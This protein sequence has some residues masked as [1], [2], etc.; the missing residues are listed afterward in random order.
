MWAQIIFSPKDLG[1]ESYPT[2]DRMEIKMQ[3]IQL[4]IW[5]HFRFSEIQIQKIRKLLPL[6]RNQQGGHSGEYGNK[7]HLGT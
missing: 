7:C 2:D 3:V 1:S 4:N 5:T 6:R